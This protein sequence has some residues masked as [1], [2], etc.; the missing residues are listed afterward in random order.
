M[1]SFASSD[2][3]LKCDYHNYLWGDCLGSNSDFLH[4]M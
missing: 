4:I 3:V 1:G 2:F